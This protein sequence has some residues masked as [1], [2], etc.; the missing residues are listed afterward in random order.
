MN[1]Q[2]PQDHSS[3]HS[4]SLAVPCEYYMS[5]GSDTSESTYLFRPHEN[6][7]AQQVVD[8]EEKQECVYSQQEH[9][10]QP[11]GTRFHK[12]IYPCL[13]LIFSF[14]LFMTCSALTRL[15]TMHVVVP[16]VD[17]S[18]TPLRDLIL[19]RLKPFPFAFKITES[20]TVFMFILLVLLSLFNKTH[21][22]S[23]LSRTFLLNSILLL[24]RMFTM[25]FT[26]LSIPNEMDIPKCAQLQH[27]TLKERL[28]GSQDHS[29]VE[30]GAL[31][32][33]CGDYMFSGH[34]CAVVLMTW[35]VLQ[36]SSLS[37]K[38]AQATLSSA[39]SLRIWK[40]MNIAMVVFLWTCCFMAMFCVLWSKEHYTCDVVVAGL[41][42]VL[43]CQVYHSHLNWWCF[44][45]NKKPEDRRGEFPNSKSLLFFKIYESDMKHC[46]NEFDLKPWTLVVQCF[47]K[48]KKVFI[49]VQRQ[50]PNEK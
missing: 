16:S 10:Q 44:W 32:Y 26:I 30:E 19:E 38:T 13:R 41:V 48:V 31:S 42:T 3:T 12:Y 14:V 35:M 45:S 36:Y 50:F 5:S 9:Q 21:R 27:M 18:Q 37:A 2:M 47:Q 24:L 20:I 28:F 11:H 39:S 29:N 23:I 17:L 8:L 40:G 46:A 25:S 49:H 34:T 22:L 1:R 7:E 4:S 43:L 33:T 15:V 6:L